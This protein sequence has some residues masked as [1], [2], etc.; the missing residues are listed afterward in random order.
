MT[1][2]GQLLRCLGSA[3]LLSAGELPAESGER[4]A[5]PVQRRADGSHGAAVE[6]RTTTWAAT[7]TA[8]IVCD[9][10]D[11]HS[12]PGAARRVQQLA[13]RVAE[14]VAA[15]RSQGVLVIH[16]PSDCMAFY[17]EHPARLRAQQAPR[18]ADLPAGMAQWQYW[19]NARE[20]AAGYPID[21]TA[22]G[23]G[24]TSE[25]K[26]AWR[27]VLAREGRLAQRW[28]WRSQHP[29]VTIDVERDVISDR[30][31]EIWNVLRSRG[32]RHVLMAGV[33]LN[34]CV[35]GRPFGIRQL[36][37][38]GMETVLL[39][40]L[41]DALFDPRR[42]P[43]FSQ[44]AG[45]T[46]MVAHVER[47]LCGTTESG[48]VF[49]G[50]SMVLPDDRRLS[51]AVLT[52]EEEYHTAETLTD[53]LENDAAE[54]FRVT[55]L[56]QDQAPGGEA[57]LHATALDSADLIL[58]SMR[59]K[60]LETTAMESLRNAVARGVP[61]VAIRTGS[62]AFALRSDAV[63]PAGR[64]V[65]PAWDAD[66]LGGNYQGHHGPAARVT[67][68]LAST[69]HPV[70]RGLAGPFASGGSL[71]LNTPLQPG[72]VTLLTGKA[73]GIAQPEPV[74][75]TSMTPAGSRSFTT[76]L[77][78]PED[79]KV[80]AFRKLLHNGLRWAARLDRE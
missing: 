23:E 43:R 59:R 31:E 3:L 68:G 58:V 6:L 11:S 20:E 38:H 14:V 69:N 12:S 17:Q 25:E 56:S 67:V 10:W 9:F 55:W 22:D 65:W 1:P 26:A 39:R 52:G 79:F 78:H 19:L 28:P 74:A 36:V 51:L 8:L 15:A 4:L 47:F 60:A 45:T 5:F 41:T 35:C 76:S 24:D 18:A 46:R 53:F 37:R 7:E 42:P 13:P 49:G 32:I 54:D 70:T 77:G 64:S 2:R 72:T 34:R 63:P 66:V 48:M 29:L 33:H 44:P 62:H 27:E 73:E 57:L 50:Q 40:D 80:P 75:W 61:V 30:G 71:Y 16:A 21:A